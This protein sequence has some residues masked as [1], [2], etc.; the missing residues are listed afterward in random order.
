V[1]AVG[2]GKVVYVG[3]YL[4]GDV[5]EELVP[6]L[7]RMAGLN[8]R[9]RGAPEGV[10]IVVRAGATRKLWFVMNHRSDEVE[11]THL[12]RG[13]DLVSGRACDGAVTLPGYGVAVIESAG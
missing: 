3:T 4:T 7:I 9:L 8:P 13:R 1:H 10:E 2:A 11:A 12:P 6:E 5:A